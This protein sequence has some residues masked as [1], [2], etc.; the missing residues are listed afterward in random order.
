MSIFNKAILA[1]HTHLTNMYP[2]EIQSLND[3]ATMPSGLFILPGRYKAYGQTYDMT[4]PG[5]YRF[6]NYTDLT[7]IQRVV[8]SQ[9]NPLPVISAM[10]WIFTQ[11]YT[12]NLLTNTQLTNVAK[13]DKLRISCGKAVAYMTWLM[14]QFGYPA[15]YAGAIT[16]KQWNYVND[17]H[18]MVEIYMDGKWVLFDLAFNARFWRDGQPLSLYDVASDLDTVEIEYMTFDTSYDV[19]GL[20][21]QGHSLSSLMEPMTSPVLLKDFYKRHLDTLIIMDGTKYYYYDA[22]LYDAQFQSWGY[23]KLTQAEWLNRFYP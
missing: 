23:V 14:P 13:Y 12:D 21:Y 11:S 16:H 10:Q 5:L 7:T 1:Y 4:A 20:W 9:T 17:G 8:Y 6:F 3:G 19:S 18:A 15:R 2:L 22:G